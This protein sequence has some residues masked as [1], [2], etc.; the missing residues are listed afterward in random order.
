MRA[1][2]SSH[3]ARARRSWSH[4]G[5]TP[6]RPCVWRRDDAVASTLRACARS[7][8]ASTRWGWSMAPHIACSSMRGRLA[9]GLVRAGAASKAP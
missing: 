2:C 3:T 9:M 5:R 6:L 7:M 8:T 4:G 1:R